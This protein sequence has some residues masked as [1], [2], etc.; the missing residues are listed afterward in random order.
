MITKPMLS[1]KFKDV[2]AD[3]AKLSYPLLATPK[4]D[5]IRALTIKGKG[6]LSRTF[7]NI[8]NKHIFKTCS[9]LPVELDGELVSGTFNETSG[10]VMR[11]EGVTPFEYHVFDYVKNGNLAEPYSERMKN[12]E[13]LQLPDFCVK[14][15]P[16]VLNSLAELE[17][18]EQKCLGE[19]FEGIMLRHPDSA[20]KCGRGTQSKMDLMKV[21]RF[22]DAE[23]K[24]TG[25]EEL[26]HNA[27]EKKEDNFG[28]GKRSSSKEN[29]HGLDS[30]GALC[31]AG[32]NGQFKGVDFKVGTGFDQALRQEIWN[33]RTTL[34]GKIVKYKYQ[35]E[36]GEDRPRFPVFLGFRDKKDM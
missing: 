25:F 6:L 35:A 26:M 8:P 11:I 20:Y 31:V 30:L 21:K 32:V 9:T 13:A 22:K 14:V 4:Y 7:K 19:G 36:G 1:G 27:N 15:L 2:E 24:I 28:R 23:A 34:T 12:L 33:K 3:L 29:K 18:Y 16:I 10:N 17:A 5:G